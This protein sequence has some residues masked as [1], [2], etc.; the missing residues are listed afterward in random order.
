MTETN[1]QNKEIVMYTMGS[2]AFCAQLKKVL[3][4]NNITFIEKDSQEYSD[5]WEHI[6]AITLVPVFPTIYMDGEYLVP[7]R[8]FQNVQHGLEVIQTRLSEGWTQPSVEIR[9]LEGIKTLNG[10]LN[11]MG[12][13]FPPIQQHLQKI[14]E[15]LAGLELA[16]EKLQNPGDPEPTIDK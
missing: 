11:M 2:C 13:N 14:N 15:S 4:E 8:D 3:K 5:E 6:K 9:L 7:R 16:S 12:Q 1:L 10:G